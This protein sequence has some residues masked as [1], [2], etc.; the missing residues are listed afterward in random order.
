MAKRRKRN[1]KI[2]SVNHQL[3]ALNEIL[4]SNGI[5]KFDIDLDAIFNPLAPLKINKNNLLRAIDEIRRENESA[6]RQSLK[7]FVVPVVFVF[8]SFWMYFT[9]LW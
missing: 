2:V 4:A 5:S 7:F 6:V 3:D 1:H 9:V 8:N